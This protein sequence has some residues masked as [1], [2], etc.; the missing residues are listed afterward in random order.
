MVACDETRQSSQLVWGPPPLSPSCSKPRAHCYCAPPGLWALNIA[1]ESCGPEPP[2]G[3]RDNDHFADPI[4][5]NIIVHCSENRNPKIRSFED[6]YK[7]LSVPGNP[8]K[9]SRGELGVCSGNSLHPLCE[10]P[11]R[12]SLF[13]SKIGVLPFYPLPTMSCGRSRQELDQLLKECCEGGVMN[14]PLFNQHFY[15]GLSA[16]AHLRIC[17]SFS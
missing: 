3:V 1:S 5:I 17:S 7:E 16:T 12:P 2:A 14:T 11:S 10:D 4:Q 9:V 8:G 6:N 13:F 15:E